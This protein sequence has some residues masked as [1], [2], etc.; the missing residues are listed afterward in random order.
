MF[1]KQ[2]QTR[3]GSSLDLQLHSNS[4]QFESEFPL[5]SS[6]LAHD[7]IAAAEASEV[8][9]LEC[10]HCTYTHLAQLKNTKAKVAAVMEL[11]TVIGQR[12][13]QFVNLL[14]ECGP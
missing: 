4:F 11:K 5:L 13:Q 14:E 9:T 3:P 8:Q 10:R 1:K 6:H 2:R 12:G 7:E